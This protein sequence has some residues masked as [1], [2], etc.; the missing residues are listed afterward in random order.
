MNFTVERRGVG[1]PTHVYALTEPAEYVLS[2]AYAPALRAILSTLRRDVDGG[3]AAWLRGAG[4][5]LARD[6]QTPTIQ[7]DAV[8]SALELLR[9][10]GAIASLERDGQNY[11]M[12]SACCPLGAATRTVP[13]MCKLLEGALAVVLPSHSVQEHCDRGEHPR[14]TFVIAAGLDTPT[15]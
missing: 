9:G 12:R 2:A 1:K 10:L 11:V 14:C 5:T 4:A 13:E 7:P 15:R 3:L 8:S 6:Q